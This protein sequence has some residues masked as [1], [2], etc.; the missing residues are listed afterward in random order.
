MSY[1]VVITGASGMVGQGVL[2]ECL[3][4]PKIEGVLMVNRR[5]VDLSHPKLKE[6]L[7]ADFAEVSS[8]AKDLE[9]YDACFFCAGVS[10]VGMSEEAYTHV[11]FGI[12]TQF[13]SVFLA[14]NADS[15]FC[16]VSGAGTDSS[17]KGRSMWARVKG[18][19]ENALLAMPFKAAYMFRP[20]YIQ[21][22]RGVKT[23]TQWYAVAY[24]IFK[25]IYALLRY[26]PSAATNS[27]HVGK[28]MIR[29]LDQGAPEQILG[30]KQIN[31]IATAN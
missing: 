25:P 5:Q 20:G 29:V 22:M 3:D 1:K 11:T 26:F 21:P 18:R 2:L 8:I 12:T 23:R 9:G 28:A 24:A 16:Y 31:A 15:V 19:T 4:S 7:L 13:A 6:V 27:V 30:N 10:A 17:E 14:Q